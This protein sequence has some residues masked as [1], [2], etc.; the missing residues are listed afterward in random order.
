M[1]VTPSNTIALG[2]PAPAFALPDAFGKTHRLDDFAGMSALL[3]AFW[4]N[5]CPFVRHIRR[6][7]AAFAREFIPKRLAIVAINS[8]DDA[9]YPEDSLTKM[10]EEVK[11]QGFIFPY[12]QDNSQDVAKA[13]RAACTPDF[14]LFDSQRKLFYH[15]QFD[16]S[17]PGNNVPVTGADLRAAAE[18]LLAGQTAPSPQAPSIGC[19][20]KW[21]RGS[22]PEWFR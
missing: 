7:F 8:N 15:G 16:G 21:R 12:L 17:R 1:A 10:G 3:V 20:I 2:T 11:I 18:R 13:Y 5:H 19:N 4:C 14:F 9:A 22:E 6:E